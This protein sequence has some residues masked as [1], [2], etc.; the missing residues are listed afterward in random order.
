[1]GDIAFDK[2]SKKE[3]SQKTIFDKRP[4]ESEE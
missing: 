4:E 3:F 1:M 2:V